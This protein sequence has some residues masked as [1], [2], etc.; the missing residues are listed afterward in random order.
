MKNGC[1]FKTLNSKIFYF[2]LFTIPQFFYPIWC[3]ENQ[4]FLLIEKN[5]DGFKCFNFQNMKII[6][7]PWSENYERFEKYIEIL[8]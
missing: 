1:I 3:E 6:H 2:E 7:I 5:K 8:I 4:L